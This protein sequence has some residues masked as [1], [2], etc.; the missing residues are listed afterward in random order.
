MPFYLRIEAFTE[1]NDYKTAIIFEPFWWA[2]AQLQSQY[3]FVAVTADSG[4]LD[5]FLNLTKELFEKIC[6]EQ[7]ERLNDSIYQNEWWTTK[8]EAV[9]T[10][11][12]FIRNNFDSYKLIRINIAEYDSTD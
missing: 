9:N 4:Y 1:L 2:K 5:Y 12:G 8:R 3:N 10:Q 6:I 11:L 7:L